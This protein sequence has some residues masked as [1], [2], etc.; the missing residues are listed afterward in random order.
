MAVVRI[1]QLRERGLVDASSLANR[2]GIGLDA[3][4]R[5]M[6]LLSDRGIVKP[7]NVPDTEETDSTHETEDAFAEG[8]YR[9]VYVG[10][11][12]AG[13]VVIYCLPKYIHRAVKLSELR[14]VF[15]SL[16]RYCSDETDANMTVLDEP[17]R[18]SR[19]SLLLALL[20]SYV[21][22]G[23]YTNQERIQQTNGRGAIHWPATISMHLPIIEDERPLYMDY[24][25]IVSRTDHSDFISR[26]H[27]AVISSCSSELEDCGL[28]DVFSMS[29]IYL[30]DTPIDEF[31][32][33][34]AIVRRLDQEL[35]VQFITWKQDVLKL[36]KVYFEDGQTDEEESGFTCYGTNSF[37][38]IWE[39]A[40]KLAFNDML[41]KKLLD[42]PIQLKGQWQQRGDETLLGIIPSPKWRVLS[43]KGEL[44]D[45]DPTDTL[46]PDIVT[47]T[48]LG[49]MA[50]EFAIY[51]AKYYAPKFGKKVVAAPGVESV[52]KQLLYQSA[53]RDFIRD[54]GF[55]HV[56]NAFL[57]PYDG[58]TFVHQGDV[59]FE[60]VANEGAPFSSTIEV[61]LSPADMVL[62]CYV[63][64]HPLPTHP[65]FEVPA[66]P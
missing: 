37:H 38:V 27:Q 48:A 1:V 24:E 36:M 63:N 18:S 22:H 11:V 23:L 25:T 59:S 60:V 17:I 15:S 64:Q 56:R 40:C 21:E 12:V 8:T 31:G 26:L 33:T 55:G 41:D 14:F 57:I 53:Y 6:G 44:I 30:S 42:L 51:D 4:R 3:G 13:E 5:L 45:C 54:N 50:N 10:V 2:A 29:P 52:S 61:F 47:M 9:I 66:R 39:R 7:A 62:D 35:G 65:S 19:I 20:N 58:Q 43:A 49:D 46:I 28:L 34:E 32:D 16:R